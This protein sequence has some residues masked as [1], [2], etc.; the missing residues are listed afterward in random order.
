MFS[1]FHSFILS[2]FVRIHIK[3][4]KVLFLF[5]SSFKYKH[6]YVNRLLQCSFMTVLM[7]LVE[8]ARGAYEKYPAQLWSI[9]KGF[10]TGSN[11]YGDKLISRSEPGKEVG[12]MELGSGKQREQL[13]QRLGGRNVPGEFET[14]QVVQFLLNIGLKENLSQIIKDLVHD[15]EVLNFNLLM[16]AKH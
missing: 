4:M 6:S 7:S 3:V 13:L 11:T 14:L 5:L 9:L 10:P 16:I 8:V 1:F 15:A 2:F 12:M